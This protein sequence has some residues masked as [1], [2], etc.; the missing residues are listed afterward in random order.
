[1]FRGLSVSCRKL[2]IDPDVGNRK[3]WKLW[4][5]PNMRTALCPAPLWP[6]LETCSLVS[7]SAHHAN[8]EELFLG[9][10]EQIRA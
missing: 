5:S 9:A 4:Q 10:S 7:P 8:Q 2:Q 3:E 6:S 1:M